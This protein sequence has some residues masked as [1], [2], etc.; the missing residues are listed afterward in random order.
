MDKERRIVKTI[1]IVAHSAEG[2]ALCFITACREG[3]LRLGPH[4]HPPIVVS[5][6]P[7]ALSMPGWESG[8]YE[9]VG[10]FLAQGVRQVADGGADF[11]VCP[12]NTAHIVLERIASELPI[13]GLHIAD[14]VCRAIV[15]GG[16]K[17]VGLLG[18]KWTM[19]GP[20]YARA[21]GER[22]LECAIPGES[23]RGRINAAIFDELCQGVFRDET[24]RLFVG[25]I[26]DLRA[27]GAE[28]VILGC[29][30][31]PLI[32]GP[33]NSP[34]PVLDSTRLLARD[35]VAEALRT[36]PRVVEEGWI[37]R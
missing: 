22:G 36:E 4:M 15:A 37:R 21:L 23:M 13:P 28:C 18:T 14:V 30:E 27:G 25:A 20:V 24:R 3:A 9:A 6:V 29:T 12:D 10:R 34:L 17:R 31:I 32:I 35:A 19:S 26:D 5:A 8:D 11:Y 16:W 33:E 7:M 2:G 1:G